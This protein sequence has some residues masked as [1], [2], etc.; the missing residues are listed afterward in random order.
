MRYFS[1]FGEVLE[2]GRKSIYLPYDLEINGKIVGYV[3][4]KDE[5]GAEEA[6]KNKK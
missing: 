6:L 2:V 4:F 1:Q 3:E 5:K